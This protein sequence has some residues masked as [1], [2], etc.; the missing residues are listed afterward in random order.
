VPQLGSDHVDGL[1]SV[2]PEILQLAAHGSI[3][4]LRIDIGAGE[5]IADIPVPLVGP[6]GDFVPVLSELLL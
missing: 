1:I 6:P 4:G 2:F 3:D 5:K